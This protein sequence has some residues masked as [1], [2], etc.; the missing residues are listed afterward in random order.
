[1]KNINALYIYIT[2]IFFINFISYILKPYFLIQI[3]EVILKI[4][5]QWTFE[6]KTI[7]A[8]YFYEHLYNKTLISINKLLIN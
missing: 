6:N 1:V 4:V 3:R 7:E 8:V 5:F 2:L